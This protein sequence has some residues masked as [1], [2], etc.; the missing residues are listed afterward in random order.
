MT[1]PV[2]MPTR[3]SQDQIEGTG[4]QRE[5]ESRPASI[6]K[7]RPSFLCV[8]HQAA[9]GMG[10]GPGAGSV[11]TRHRMHLLRQVLP[12]PLDRAGVLQHRV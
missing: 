10:F 3:I 9:G 11:A 7:M 1:T 6:Y 12:S 8:W 2:D 5:T 4:G